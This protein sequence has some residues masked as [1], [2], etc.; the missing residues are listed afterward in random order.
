MSR[1]IIN[2]LACQDLDEIA[3]YFSQNSLEAGK[4]FFLAFNQK[5]QQLVSFP[6]TGKSYAY[7]RPGLRGL[8]F[9][10]YIIFYRILKDGIEILRVLNGRRNFPTLFAASN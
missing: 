10:G 7:I 1:Y 4:R 6:N 5:C 8:S 3:D 2:R 9:E